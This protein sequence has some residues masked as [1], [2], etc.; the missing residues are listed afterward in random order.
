MATLG[1]R[2]TSARDT[3]VALRR[4]GDPLLLGAF[5]LAFALATIAWGWLPAWGIGF[6]FVGTL[7]EPARGVLDG[8][9]IYPDP[10]RESIVVGN[11]SVY[12]PPAIVAAVPLAVLPETAAAWLWFAVLGASVLAAL[13]IVGVRDWRCLVVAVASPVVVHG[14]VFGNLTVLLALAVAVAWRYRDATR[15]VGLAVGGAVAAK[16]VVWPLLVWLVATRRY[17]AA[18]LAVVSAA[19]LVLGTWAVLGFEGMTDYPALLG[20]LQDVYATRSVSLATIAG[21][22]GASVPWAV[23]VC[24][25]AGLVLVGIAARLA[26]ARAGERPAFAVAVA[27]CVVAS[28]IVWPYYSALLFVPIALVWSRFS[29]AWLFGYAI[30]LVGVIAPKSTL[31][32]DGACCRPDDVPEQA[33]LWSHAD[34]SPWYAAGFTVVVLVVSAWTARAARGVRA[35]VADKLQILR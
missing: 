34:P 19:V 16:F 22:F 27:A 28:P 2:E 32:E 25:A 5:P 33:W 6:D 24:W 10:T 30:W 1:H 9:P 11:P 14:L 21:A 31:V 20:E 12:P 23:A 4:V 3:W 15:V 26:R 35:P 29:L 8:G 7:W 18:V 17:R 13:W